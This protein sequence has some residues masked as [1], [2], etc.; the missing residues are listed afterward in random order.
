MHGNGP[1][2]HIDRTFKEKNLSDLD[3]D[4][5]KTMTLAKTARD[6]NYSCKIN[7]VSQTEIVN[8]VQSINYSINNLIANIL[9]SSR[10][11]TCLITK[12]LP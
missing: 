5:I 7:K 8:A 2:P 12:S 4:L 6:L 11:V 9:A 10:N 3:S 1:L